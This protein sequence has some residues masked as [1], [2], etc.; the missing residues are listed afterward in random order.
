MVLP[1][2]FSLCQFDRI[3]SPEFEGIETK[4]K[5][6]VTKCPKMVTDYGN[7]KKDFSVF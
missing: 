4:K 2:D 3:N 6:N 1:P 5:K 7:H